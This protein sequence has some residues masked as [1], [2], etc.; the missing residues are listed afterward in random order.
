MAHHMSGAPLVSIPSIALF[1]VVGC[2]DRC[3]ITSFV[4]PRRWVKCENASSARTPALC[5]WGLKPTTAIFQNLYI[6]MAAQE[7]LLILEGTSLKYA[8]TIYKNTDLRLH[9]LSTASI[10]H[11]VSIMRAPART[12]SK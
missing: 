2:L 7:V 4:G 1:L 6:K 11:C 8:I 5:A 10:E 3:A 9:M 12:S